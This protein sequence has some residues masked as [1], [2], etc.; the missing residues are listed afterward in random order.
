[1]F[2]VPFLVPEWLERA[3][4]SEDRKIA[5]KGTEWTPPLCEEAPSLLL[6]GLVLFV[7]LSL[8]RMPSGRWP[9]FCGDSLPA[10]A[11]MILPMFGG[12]VLGT[13]LCKGDSGGGLVFVKEEGQLQ[14]HYLRGI[15]S[16]APNNNKLCNTH[17]IPTFTHILAHERFIK[18]QLNFT[19][20]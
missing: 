10:L 6:K 16:T 15:S 3:G 2:W 8:S 9:H 13:A 7:G 11:L 1:M 5:L 4:L 20:V 12:R 19:T 14:R 18:D 17:A